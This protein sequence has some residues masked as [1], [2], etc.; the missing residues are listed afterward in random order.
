[1][2]ET[3]FPLSSVSIN[4]SDGELRHINGQ[5][6]SSKPRARH[7]LLKELTLASLSDLSPRERKF[8]QHIRSSHTNDKLYPPYM[9]DKEFTVFTIHIFN[10][11]IL[12]VFNFNVENFIIIYKFEPALELGT[13]MLSFK[14]WMRISVLIIHLMR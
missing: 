1:V 5:S 7:S 3:S 10:I 11:Y 9:P 2:K 8:Y 13:S 6:S 12:I 14:K 4:V